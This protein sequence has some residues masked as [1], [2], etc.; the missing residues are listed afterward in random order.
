M[1]DTSVGS[2]F[3]VNRAVVQNTCRRLCQVHRPLPSRVAPADREVG[4]LEDVAVE[5]GGP[6]VLARRRGEDQP[7]RVGAG[8]LLGAGLLDAGGEPLGERVAGGRAARVD[9]PAELAV[10]RRFYVEVPGDLDHLAVHRDH[11][12]GLVDLRD[13]QRG[14]LAPPQPAVGGGAGH[15]LIPLAVPPGGQRPAELA[16]VAVGRDLGG[17]D[18]QRRF[19]GCAHP[20]ARAAGGP[21]PASAPWPAAGWPG[22]RRRGPR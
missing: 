14:Q 5:V 19:P 22:T 4:A 15:Q 2:S 3:Q 16:D 11:P 13:G 18:P 9:R 17:V 1:R 12:A 8:V 10:L 6:P 21:R 7:E 20:R